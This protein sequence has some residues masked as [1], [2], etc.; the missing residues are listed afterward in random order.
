MSQSMV[1]MGE[2][3]PEPKSHLQTRSPQHPQEGQEKVLITHAS[4]TNKVVL[5]LYPACTFFFFLLFFFFPF[6]LAIFLPPFLLNR[7]YYSYQYSKALCSVRDQSLGLAHA[8]QRL[9]TWAL[10][11]PT[12][13]VL[14]EIPCQ[15]GQLCPL[16]GTRSASVQVILVGASVPSWQLNCPIFWILGP[17]HRIMRF[18]SIVSKVFTLHGLEWLVQRVEYLSCMHLTLGFIP[19]IPH[20]AL[21][22]PRLIPNCRARNNS[23]ALLRS[24]LVK[25]L[26]P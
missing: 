8:K 25:G 17:I 1:M 9:C 23:W 2:Q 20:G 15:D 11:L 3:K 22:Q 5:H 4:M 7:D 18:S 24:H 26:G 14:K 21:R 12:F 19:G 6:F 16:I 13:L 10:S